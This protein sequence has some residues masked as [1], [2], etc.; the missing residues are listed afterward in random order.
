M[1]F[2]FLLW[3]VHR[4]SDGYDDEKLIGVYDT[5][6]KAEAAISRLRERPGFVD[7]PS[8]FEIAKYE[9]NRDHW[10]DGYASV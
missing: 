8:G 6:D 4:I 2:V 1:A 10:A 3:H 9:L 7:E 5:E